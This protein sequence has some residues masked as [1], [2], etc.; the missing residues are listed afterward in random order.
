MRRLNLLGKVFGKLTV[1]SF[2]EVRNRQ[3]FWNTSCACGG[4]KTVGMSCLQNGHTRSCGCLYLE[5][6]HLGGLKHGMY[7]TAIYQIWNRI[8]QSTTNPKNSSW[9]NYG[10]R[11]ITIDPLWLKFENFYADMGDRPE[12]LE[13]DREK[14]HLGYC[15]AN[16][17]WVTRKA[18]NRNKRTN[19][20]LLYKGESITVVEA[21]ELSGIPYNTLWNRLVR[22]NNP[23]IF[24]KVK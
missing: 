3:A 18:N 6:D 15:K 2:A 17:R 9:K 23:D 8:T 22:S 5:A 12:G 24:R 4:F 14:N 11:G 20:L 16:C 19:R 13:L 7:G 21:S 1:I 10:G